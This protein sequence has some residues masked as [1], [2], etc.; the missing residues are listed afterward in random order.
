MAEENCFQIRSVSRKSTESRALNQLHRHSR[1]EALGQLH[2]ALQLQAGKSKQS[3]LANF[4]P[5]LKKE[6]NRFW[7]FKLLQDQESVKTRSVTVVVPRWKPRRQLRRKICWPG[8]SWLKMPWWKR[9]STWKP[10]IVRATSAAALRD[11]QRF[12]IKDGM[13]ILNEEL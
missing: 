7:D 3:K 11:H 4:F 10:P 13:T 2:Q 5:L 8:T 6:D 12:P 9:V 1:W